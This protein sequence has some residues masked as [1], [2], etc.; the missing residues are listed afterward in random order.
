MIQ[1]RQQK[2]YNKGRDTVKKIVMIVLLG[3]VISC[4]QKNYSKM[5]IEEL[6]LEANKYSLSVQGKEK[7]KDWIEL[8]KI[9][10]ILERKQ[11]EEIWSA[12]FLDKDIDLSKN[13]DSKKDINKMTLEELEILV[14]KKEHELY[15][16]G[17]L[18]NKDMV[19]LIK[20]REIR[21]IK[22]EERTR[23]ILDKRIQEFREMRKKKD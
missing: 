7:G 12:D 13:V 9:L 19:K 17:N 14:T 22:R 11:N 15:E 16:K 5:S 18:P 3:L 4:G 8:N 10:M 1:N 20:A 6:V 21:E 2:K 23:E